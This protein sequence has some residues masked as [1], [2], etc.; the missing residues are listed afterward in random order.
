MSNDNPWAAQQVEATNRLA[1]AV[2]ALVK[3]TASLGQLVGGVAVE[4][5]NTRKERKSSGEAAR[6]TGGA[7]R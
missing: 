6:P 4:L 7:S 3:V 5:E 2:E 1:N